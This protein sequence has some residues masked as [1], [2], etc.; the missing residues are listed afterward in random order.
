MTIGGIGLGSYGTQF[1][2]S[3]RA[4]TTAINDVNASVDRLGRGSAISVKANSVA[5]GI[6]QKTKS[7]IAGWD[8]A[9]KL[10]QKTRNDLDLLLT[11][12]EN[13]KNIVYDLKPT[14]VMAMDENLSDLDRASLDE[15]YKSV[16][17]RMQDF[18][19]NSASYF[20]GSASH[21]AGFNRLEV[22]LADKDGPGTEIAFT[23]RNL[24][25][26]ALEDF[27]PNDYTFSSASG[28]ADFKEEMLDQLINSDFKD[29]QY[30]GTHT[31]FDVVEIAQ[32]FA[33]KMSDV[34]SKAVLDLTDLEIE[35]EVARLRQ[36]QTDQVRAESAQQI[37]NQNLRTYTSVLNDVRA[38]TGRLVSFYA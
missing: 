15:E 31:P 33:A 37:A 32:N 23:T 12:N 24:T 27:N 3:S 36:A 26:A 13:I 17:R 18:Y 20:P 19:N 30:T 6:A 11:F 5:Y 34:A 1:I 14:V 4:Y 25:A 10:N 7:D 8:M 9:Q 29:K 38:Q 35:A 2:R 16:A 22:R 21:L 28:A